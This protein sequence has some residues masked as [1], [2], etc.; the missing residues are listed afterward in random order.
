ME[1]IHIRG[2]C[3]KSSW[4]KILDCIDQ[5]KQEGWFIQERTKNENEKTNKVEFNYIMNKNS[6]Y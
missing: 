5:L 6:K 1:N 4:Y 2:N 3:N